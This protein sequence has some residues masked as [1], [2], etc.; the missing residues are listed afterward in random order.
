MLAFIGNKTKF[1]NQMV[2]D[3]WPN[4]DFD[5]DLCYIF[6]SESDILDPID[7]FS[8]IK[9]LVSFER[10]MLVDYDLKY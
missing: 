8:D 2:F 3:K 6:V 10:A 9:N 7:N 5:T 4:G 1:N